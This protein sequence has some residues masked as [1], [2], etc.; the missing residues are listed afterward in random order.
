M[1]MNTFYTYVC[2]PQYTGP[3]ENPLLFYS[4]LQETVTKPIEHNELELYGDGKHR[5]ETCI[6]KE[7]CSRTYYK[8]CFFFWG[9]LGK[10]SE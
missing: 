7:K 8:F 10:S 6:F 9:Q 2:A 3:I 1:I 4:C 5:E